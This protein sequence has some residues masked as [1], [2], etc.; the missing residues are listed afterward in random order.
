MESWQ[1]VCLSWQKKALKGVSINLCHKPPL[2]IILENYVGMPYIFKQHPVCIYS[3]LEVSA[4]TN[5]LG[6]YKRT[7]TYNTSFQ[8]TFLEQNVTLSI[9]EK[10]PNYTRQKIS[11]F[12]KLSH[13][14]REETLLIYQ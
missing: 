3:R 7:H 11:I 12:N 10:N 5:N 13:K 14:I 9:F 8:G 6:N 4:Q 2:E 1:R